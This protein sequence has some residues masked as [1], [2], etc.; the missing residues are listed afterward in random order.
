[1]IKDINH[2]VIATTL[3]FNKRNRHLVRKHTWIFRTGFG[4]QS[5]FDD[6]WWRRYFS[7]LSLQC[8]LPY[9]FKNLYRTIWR[10]WSSFI[11]R[12]NRINRSVTWSCWSCTSFIRCLSQ[13]SSVSGKAESTSIMVVPG[14]RICI[15][16]Q[17]SSSHVYQFNNL[18]IIL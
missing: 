13:S 7:W 2:R 9:F 18:K 10:A 1:M 16:R 14:N 3:S 6:G 12:V 15:W 17:L 4:H 5:Q 11:K 8:G